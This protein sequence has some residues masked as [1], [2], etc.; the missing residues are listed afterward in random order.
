MSEPTK[1]STRKPR[2]PAH[3]AGDLRAGIRLDCDDPGQLRDL[4][5]RARAL[6]EAKAPARA[7]ASKSM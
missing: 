4:Y 2:E 6:L 5:E 3:A 1:Q 7:S